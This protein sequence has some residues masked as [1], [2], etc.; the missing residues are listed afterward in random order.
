MKILMFPRYFEWKSLE[1][2]WNI[3]LTS[4]F[5]WNPGIFCRFSCFTFLVDKLWAD[6]FISLDYEPEKHLDVQKY[7]C[8]IC[9]LFLFCFSV[10]LLVS[11]NV[12]FICLVLL[13]WNVINKRFDL[14]TTCDWQFFVS[15]QLLWRASNVDRYVY[16][17]EW[18]SVCA[19]S[20]VHWYV[21]WSLSR[22]YDLFWFRFQYSGRNTSITPILD[23]N[24]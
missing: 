13:S 7:N 15:W 10:T 1:N 3:I 14:W 21:L 18:L 24:R 11:I 6:P 12:T 19:C 9:T 17:L 5:V 4:W 22:A 23:Q 16:C 2:A 8:V 20:Y